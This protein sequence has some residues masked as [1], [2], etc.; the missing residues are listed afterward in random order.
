MKSDIQALKAL[1]QAGRN[2]HAQAQQEVATRRALKKA[3][4]A[5]HTDSLE[6]PKP[7]W[8]ASKLEKV[9]REEMEEVY[10]HLEVSRW[11]DKEYAQAKKLIERYP[12]CCEQL[13]RWAVR[14]WEAYVV[15][16]QVQ[17]VCSIGNI[18]VHAELL[19][20]NRLSGLT[21]VQQRIALKDQERKERDQWREF[22]GGMNPLEQR[23]EEV[24]VQEIEW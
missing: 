6:P 5:Q 17:G 8:V 15:T 24:A 12:V 18:L 11:K 23:E 9:Y 14:Q 22:Q 16:Q 13:V 10:T 19:N 7:V 1:Q 21:P 3:Q 20:Q 4:Q 2:Q